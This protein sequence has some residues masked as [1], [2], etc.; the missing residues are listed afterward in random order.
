MP[1]VS[2]RRR[3]LQ[4]AGIALGG[5]TV[6]L[7]LSTTVAGAQTSAEAGVMSLARLSIFTAL[8]EAVAEVR[9]AGD[10]ARA[11]ARLSRWYGEADLADRMQID[12]ALD[13]L[14]ALPGTLPVLT[15]RDRLTLL[16]EHLHGPHA[17][18]LTTAIGLAVTGLG[19][20]EAKGD[21]AAAGRLYAR[22]I[23][24]LPSQPRP[25]QGG[26]VGVEPDRAEPCTPR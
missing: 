3:F 6:A 5:G 24:A 18:R 17:A 13:T 23:R 11:T 9:G 10:A 14:T 19:E 2:N 20:S 8:S 26:Q 15:P 21:A 25:A 4:A 12:A 16:A 7:G 22:T 1:Q